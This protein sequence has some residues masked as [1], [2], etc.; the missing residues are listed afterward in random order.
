MVLI[1]TK[2]KERRRAQRFPLGT[3]GQLTVCPAIA[4]MPPVKV[5]VKDASV[6]GVG[7]IHDEPLR[8][9]QKYVIREKTL[10]RR[11]S[12]LFTVVR[13][14]PT[15]DGKYSIGLHASHLMGRDRMPLSDQRG[16][17]VRIFGL[18]IAIV[19]V[20]GVVAAGFLL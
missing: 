3:E 20:G 8:V 18:L 15:G 9:G 19:L 13:C 17:G 12:V 4:G 7:I 14:E 16:R 1:G 10:S 2:V 11:K 6:T 5:R